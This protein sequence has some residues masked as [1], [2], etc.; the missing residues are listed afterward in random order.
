[1][2]VGLA[3][4]FSSRFAQEGSH[5]MNVSLT[6]DVTLGCMFL[7]VYNVAVVIV[8]LTNQ[9]RLPAN[10][11]MFSRVW[12]CTYLALACVLGLSELWKT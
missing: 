11:Y 8:G 1:M 7:V 12:Y 2:L 10:F 5:S 4:G 6:P 3:L 9:F